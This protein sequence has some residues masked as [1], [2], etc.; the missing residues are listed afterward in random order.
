MPKSPLC[1]KLAAVLQTK[2]AG[3]RFRWSAEPPPLV[4]PAHPLKPTT[5][6]PEPEGSVN[7][8]VGS[9]KMPDLGHQAKPPIGG[10]K[11]S[12][13]DLALPVGLGVAGGATAAGTIGALRGGKPSEQAGAPAAA[14]P[15]PAASGGEPKPEDGGLMAPGG[16]LDKAWSYAKE[17]PWTTAGIGAAGVGAGIGAVALL[18]YLLSKDDDN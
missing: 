17:N 15:A 14:T 5:Y 12:L 4:V 9:M 7:P 18:R 16:T 1:R 13:R 8:A 3:G 6:M 2:T 10:D 11:A